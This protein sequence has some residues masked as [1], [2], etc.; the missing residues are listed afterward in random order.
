MHNFSIWHFCIKICDFFQI[1][2][3]T[4]LKCNVNTRKKD[5]RKSQKWKFL[6][7]N[8]NGRIS[9][10]LETYIF[11]TMNWEYNMYY[12]KGWARLLRLPQHD[13]LENPH[14]IQ[15]V[16]C[17]RDKILTALVTRCVFYKISCG[18]IRQLKVVFH[19]FEIFGGL[20]LCYLKRKKV[21]RPISNISFVSLVFLPDI[22]KT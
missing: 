9:V 16:V 6:L 21:F 1:Y 10:K 15:H 14:E 18:K 3:S 8:I 22:L 20:Y 19:K 2:K 4:T 12:P 11:Y 5:V 17:N 13:S 7:W